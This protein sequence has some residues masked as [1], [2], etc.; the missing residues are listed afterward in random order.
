M[1]L[2]NFRNRL[3]AVL[4]LGR[5]GLSVVGALKDSGAHV[6][7]WDDHS[8]SLTQAKDMGIEIVDFR[9]IQWSKISSFIVSPS[10]PLTGDKAHW[11]V[12]LA[13]QFN[14]EIIGDIELFV[15]ERRFSAFHSPFIAVT[16][17]NGKSSTVML[18]SHILNQNGYDVQLGGNIGNPILNLAYFSSHRFY[19]IECSS[20]QID[21]T[22]TI[23]PS[24]GVLL[25]VS[26]DHLDRHHTLENYARIKKKLVA[27]SQHAVICMNDDLC[28]TVASDMATAGHSMT[29]IS[30]QP[31]PSDSDFYIDG[32][33]IKCSST[34]KTI[35][36]L[37]QED[38]RYNMHNVAA[39]IAVCMRLGLKIDEIK[40][41]ISS[42][43]GL[44]HRLQKIAQLGQ[45]IFIND[46]K[47]TNL[48]SV[49]HAFLNEKRV[50]YWIGGGLSKSDDFSIIFPFLSKVAKA[51]FI[52]DSATI[53]AHHLRERVEYDVFQT[54]DQALT[55]VVRD[56]VNTTIPSVVLFSPG[57]ASFDQYKSFKERGFSFMSQV[58]EIKNIQMLV[59]IEE[60]RKFP[61]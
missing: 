7:A 53:F 54:L 9:T 22:P 16:G 13:N 27:K 46:S 20:Y 58:S 8:H 56:V 38:R 35:F 55:S 34:S 60:E 49:V 59:D 61:W 28:K 51:Y 1:N 36:S 17:T 3:I 6:I 41:A 30:S 42:F 39:S 26:I 45:V 15:R 4:G 32:S 44:T 14:V 37:S 23:D 33:H 24:I 18:I 10:I 50:I 2:K 25:N 52:G 47:A 11:C 31:M 21:L 48:H 40:R 29:R 19:V 43:N 12:K 57:C 5:S